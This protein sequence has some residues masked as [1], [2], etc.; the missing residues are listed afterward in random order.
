[1]S[2]IPYYKQKRPLKNRDFCAL[3]PYLFS[4]ETR[5]K[6]PCKIS[7]FCDREFLTVLIFE[8][9][10]DTPSRLILNS[11]SFLTRQYDRATALRETRK[12]PIHPQMPHH[13][14]LH[15]YVL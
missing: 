2:E 6:K 14:R 8:K 3:E 4:D 10:T 15:S 9:N 5:A 11:G 12:S 1:F 7:L 13:P